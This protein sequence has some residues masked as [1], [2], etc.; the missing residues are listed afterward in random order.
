MS[1]TVRRPL[2]VVATT[3][4]AVLLVGSATGAPLAAANN[5]NSTQSTGPQISLSDVSITPSRPAPGDLVEISAEVSNAAT[6]SETAEVQTVRL[7]S[8]SGFK[9]YGQ[10]RDLG[11]VT[12][13]GSVT[14]PLTTTFEEPGVKKLELTVSV[15]TNDDELV[16]F[17]YPVTVVVSES[18]PKM[19]IDVAGSVGRYREIAVNVSN[20]QLDAIRNLDL[21]LD[22][23]NVR[24]GD[25]ERLDAK[26]EPGTKRTF[27][28]SGSIPDGDTGS[29]TAILEYTN[30]MGQTQELERTVGLDATTGSA[31]VDGPQLAL[32]VADGLPG[33]N[34]PVNVTVAN[35]LE[36]DLS[37]VEVAVDSPVATFT[38]SERVT[39]QLTAGETTDF[40]FPARVTESGSYPVTVTL[41]YTDDGTR[42]QVTERFQAAFDAPPNPG[43]IELTGVE[44]VARGG[45][46]EITATASNVG[47]DEVKS[48]IVSTGEAEN[49]GRKKY[50]VGSVDASDFS[51]FTLEP[52]VR[53]NV[54]TVPVEVSYVVD[55][56]RRNYTTEIPV[57]QAA[58]PDRSPQRG[59]LPIVPIL[60]VVAVIAA[61]VIYRRRG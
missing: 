34:R 54:S 60:V 6:S 23:R 27:T 57:T 42:K 32:S 11:T 37:Q 8:R 12:P 19:S 56:V 58:A 53:G 44:A 45:T 9:R 46:L 5:V 3:V 24:I 16:Q 35:G 41:N 55:D 33:T 13:G 30:A 43:A 59:G 15:K 29:V 7:E 48:V 51:S 61:V 39:S 4:V 20:G 25:P 26:L 36:G 52:S 40:R 17:N 38:A 18:G 10:V 28:Y 50:F 14:A 22:G 47:S 49:V 2:S 21:T 31:A 1:P